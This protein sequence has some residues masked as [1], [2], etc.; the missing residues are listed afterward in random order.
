MRRGCWAGKLNWRTFWTNT[1]SIYASQ[2]R[3]SLNL[4]YLPT[5][6]PTAGGGTAILV[7]SVIAQNS[8]P[9]PGLTHLQAPVDRPVNILEAYLSPSHL[10]IGAKPSTSFWRWLT[11]LLAGDLNPKHVD[12]NW[13]LSTRGEISYVIILF[14]MA[15]IERHTACQNK[16]R[17]AL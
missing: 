14:E 5:H 1:L 4:L 6:R 3:H 9:N 15:Q 2:M 8:V 7:C 13:R 11:V 12:W 17:K 10:L 16:I